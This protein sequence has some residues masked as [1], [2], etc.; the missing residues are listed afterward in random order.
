MKPM[1]P[2][3]FRPKKGAS[4]KTQRANNDAMLDWLDLELEQQTS[5]ELSDASANWRLMPLGEDYD[6]LLARHGKPEKLRERYPKFADCI[7][8]PKRRGKPPQLRY[9]I[10]S[11]KFVVGLAKRI[12]KLWRD[13]YGLVVRKR[14]EKTAEQFAL[15]IYNGWVGNSGLTMRAVLAAKKP[16]GKR[17]SSRT[18]SR[19]K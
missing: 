5:R 8:S 19:L 2:E 15:D 4:L 14:G 6:I 16:S 17:K 13:N 1:P 11:V 10:S 3:F 12:R 9:S 18:N 7:Q